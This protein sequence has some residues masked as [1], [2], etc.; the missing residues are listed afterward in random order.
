VGGGR[1]SAVGPAPSEPRRRSRARSESASGVSGGGG[2]TP[3]AYSA[4]RLAPCAAPTCA[5]PT[6]RL[7][8]RSDGAGPTC[9]AAHRPI[10]YACRSRVIPALIPTSSRRAATSWPAPDPPR[11]LTAPRRRPTRVVGQQDAV[12]AL[13]EGRHAARLRAGCAV[14]R[15]AC[16]TAAGDPHRRSAAANALLPARAGGREPHAPCCSQRTTAPAAGRLSRTPHPITPLAAWQVTRSAQPHSTQPLAAPRPTHPIR[17][18]PGPPPLTHCPAMPTLRP[19][20]NRG[21]MP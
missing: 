5:A 7:R 6:A 2:D 4:R 8:R 18:S 11:R 12:E 19:D 9:A 14:A 10:R 3:P 1:R 15:R 17:R 16:Q 13:L 21:S 20:L